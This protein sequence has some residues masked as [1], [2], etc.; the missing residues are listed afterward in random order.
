MRNIKLRH[1]RRGVLL[2]LRHNMF[3]QMMVVFVLLSGAAVAMLSYFL[4]RFI[5]QSVIDNELETQKA[6]IE[7]VNSYLQRQ[8]DEMRT[9]LN[10]IYRDHRLAQDMVYYLRH[11]FEEYIQQRLDQQSEGMLLPVPPRITDTLQ[12]MLSDNP[13]IDRMMLYGSERQYLHIYS[14]SQSLRILHTNGA[15]S[16]IP[17]VMSMEGPSFTLPNVWIRKAT[18]IA[19]TGLYSIRMA[20]NDPISI[21]EIGQLLFYFRSDDV[22]NAIRSYREQLKGDILVL[23]SDGGVM[24]D[25]SGRHYG[26]PYPYMDQL[27]TLNGRGRL[28]ED[29]YFSTISDYNSGYLVAGVVSARELETAYQ[30]AKRTIW[31]VSVAAM[32]LVALLSSLF[33]L[34][35]AKRTHQILRFM[36]KVED[37]D[38][39]ARL[40]DGREDELGLISA[41]FNRMMDELSRHIESEYKAEIK[42]KHAEMSALQARIQPHFLYNTLEVIRMR[43]L[44]SG[45]ADVADMIYSLAMLFKSFVNPSYETTL[46]E[47]MDMCRLYLELFRIRYKD[48]FSYAIEYEPSLGRAKTIR[49]LLQPAVENYIVHGLR[50]DRKDNRLTI[51]AYAIGDDI[52]IVVEDNGVGIPPD[53][54]DAL[55]QSLRLPETEGQ[56]FGL[57]SVHQRLELR[58]G[59][60]YGLRIRSGDSGTTIT[61]KFPAL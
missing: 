32:A 5:A 38:L 19:E 44:S 29:A 54:L 46:R 36:R 50:K 14:P 60:D 43:A 11:P 1:R 22:R 49:M 58:Y 15:L 52:E 61:I 24:F 13:A 41:S 53:R 17:D 10:G 34:N 25:S 4:Y 6:A 18:G 33:V 7:S 2:S 8:Q 48:S 39:D 35:Y 37:G 42:Q 57:R 20:V 51:R 12:N 9:F 26:R 45:V 23:A 56:S 16:Y 30:G 55:Q 59:A 28:G 27:A 40:P 47:E 31:I 21:T 3:I